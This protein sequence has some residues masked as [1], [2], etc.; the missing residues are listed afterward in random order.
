ME[1]IGTV[2]FSIVGAPLSGKTSIVHRFFDNTF[3]EEYVY[4][5]HSQKY[6]KTLKTNTDF[7]FNL[8]VWDDYGSDLITLFAVTASSRGIICTVDSTKILNNDFSDY[9]EGLV[10]VES[11]RKSKENLPFLLLATK[12]DLLSEEQKKQVEN[13]IKDLAKKGGFIE[14]FLCSAKEGTGLENAFI[15]LLQH[16]N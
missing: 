15:Y 7:I 3:S 9:E 1:N 16:I 11:I 6:S 10:K 2:T 4:K 14:G 5:D 13:S 12:T 8:D